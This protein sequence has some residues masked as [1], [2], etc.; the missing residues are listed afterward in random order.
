MITLM[1]MNL[2]NVIRLILRGL[3]PLLLAAVLA[4]SGVP[5]TA[6][7]R[8]NCD[9]FASQEEAQAEL[10]RT[11][12]DDP[13]RLDR[14]ED[15]IACESEFGL[16]PEEEATIVP[17]GEASQTRDGGNREPRAEPTAAPVPA[18]DPNQTADGVT[19]PDDVLARVEG[20]AVI[21]ISSRSVAAAGCPGGQPILLRIPADAPP[22]ESTVIFNHGAP[23]TTATGT[24]TDS[25]AA[26]GSRASTQDSQSSAQ[27]RERRQSGTGDETGS[28]KNQNKDKDQNDTG[29]QGGKKDK[30][31]KKDKK[32]KM[33]KD[34]KKNKDGKNNK[35]NKQGKNKN[36]RG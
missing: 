31:D 27:T 6:Q 4:I 13:N 36:K 34:G 11:F 26:T 16:T 29:G 24:A 35:N 19:A 17:A 22:M 33:G 30:K 1:N 14:D 28:A 21:A 23:L 15:G 20:C 25:T 2:R 8:L 3:L 7:D 9:A 32:N 10:E 5:V 18:P 12:P